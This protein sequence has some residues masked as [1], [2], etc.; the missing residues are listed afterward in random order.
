MERRERA[1]DGADEH[2]L[3]LASRAWYPIFSIKLRSA[4][5]PPKKAKHK[6]RNIQRSLN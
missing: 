6:K 2:L 3:V 4:Q 5:E 1:S